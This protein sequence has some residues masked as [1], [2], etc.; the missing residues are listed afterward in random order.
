VKQKRP[1][2]ITEPKRAVARPP[3]RLDVEVRS[4]QG[5]PLGKVIDDR[6][7]DLSFGITQ[8]EEPK[9]LDLAAPVSG[10]FHVGANP[11]NAQ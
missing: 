4:C 3:H 11:V 8:L 5:A 10:G 2:L 9:H 7:R 1:K 6:E